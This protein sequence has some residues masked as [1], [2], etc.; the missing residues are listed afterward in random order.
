[1]KKMAKWEMISSALVF[2]NKSNT[3]HKPLIVNA[4]SKL[5]GQCWM[6]VA[7]CLSLFSSP[8]FEFQ[9]FFVLCFLLKMT[10]IYSFLFPRKQ[11]SGEIERSENWSDTSMRFEDEL[12]FELGTLLGICAEENSYRNRRATKSYSKVLGLNFYI[13]VLC[14]TF[15]TLLTWKRQKPKNV[16]G[17]TTKKYLFG[18]MSVLP[19]GL[20]TLSEWGEG[21]EF[22]WS[23][24]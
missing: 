1:M 15:L 19:M 14:S 5:F 23:S 24:T 21:P 20:I 6:F 8:K 12:C 18:R 22:S 9:N 16:H 4:L 13:L 11:V 3:E 2:K 17:H 10:D 7:Y